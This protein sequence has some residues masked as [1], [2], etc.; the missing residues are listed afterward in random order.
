[1]SADIVDRVTHSTAPKKNRKKLSGVAQFWLIF[2]Y[3]S[4]TIILAMIILPIYVLVVNSFKGI[5]GVYLNTAFQLPE[6]INFETWAAAWDWL[7]VPMGRTLLFVT[8]SSIISAL[9]GSIN[10]YVLSKWRF[11]GSNA[12]FM[13]FLFGMFIPYQAIMIPLT[14]FNKAVGLTGS[15]YVLVL[16]HVVYGIPICTL[17]FRNYYASI[18]DEIIEAGRVDGAS[19]VRI[20]R[21]IIL[22]LSIPAF[23]VVLIWQFTSA[24][25]DFLFAIFLTGGSPK[26][27]VATTALNWLTGSSNQVY[28]GKNMTASLMASIPTLLV[29]MFLGRYFLRGLLSGSLKG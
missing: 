12:V 18:P 15:I 21:A 19:M 5:S 26:L 3:V 13:L 22:P 11:T 2:R 29:Y 23:V 1:M 4:L 8:Q 7:A 10:G 17:I 28:Y 16:A 24:W 25:N 9:I 6:K 14:Q 27:A 20:Y